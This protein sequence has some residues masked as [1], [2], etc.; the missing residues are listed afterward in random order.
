MAEQN[1]ELVERLR[2][3]GM[4]AVSG[5]ASD[6][7]VLIQAHVA[8]A[9]T[10]VIAT[11]DTARARVMIDIARRLNPR[12]DI[13]VRTHSDEEAELLRKDHVSSG[14]HGRAR[15]RQQHDRAHPDERERAE[16]GASVA[17][18]ERDAMSR[19]RSPAA[20]ARD[21][22][23][24]LK[25]L[26]SKRNRDGMA[27][28]GIVAQKVFGV[29]V[30]TLRGIGKRLGRDHELAAALWDTGWYEA[31]MLAAF[32]DDPAD[33]TSG[34]M[35]RWA[36][37]FD[38]WAI[39]DT[40]CFHLFDHT[41][42]AWRKVEQWSGRRDEFVKRAAFALLAS[43]SVHDKGADDQLFLRGL[44]LIEQGRDRRAQLRQE[45]GQL[46]ASLDRQEKSSAE[47]GLRSPSRSAFPT[48]RMP[49]RDGSARMP[50]G[51]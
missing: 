21:V 50:T 10:L 23:A 1:R 44:R 22:L 7:G 31:R 34:Q 3:R 25:R 15:A 33:V 11:P 48:H 28:Y 39:C 6:A 46:G 14:V 35:D 49:P 38:N 43:L 12:I 16:V 40:I 30:G 47:R 4:L 41:T 17:G 19:E 36:R 32:V 29:S 37:D 18:P 51:S 42:H 45:G 9:R 5:D 26:G 27:R 2:E 13:V 8:R 20:R 24:T